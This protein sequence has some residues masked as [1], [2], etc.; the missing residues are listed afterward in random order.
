MSGETINGKLIPLTEVLTY[1]QSDH[2]MNRTEAARYCGV[3]IRTF[4]GW[5][6]QLPKYRPGGRDLYKRSELDAFMQRH[7]EQPTDVD[8]QR[9]I[10]DAIQAV[11]R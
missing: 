4:E 8:L 2:Y 9:L 10:D 1:L 3:S 5:R 6:D 7:L 11:T